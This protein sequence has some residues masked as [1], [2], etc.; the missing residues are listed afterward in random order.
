MK[1]FLMALFALLSLVAINGAL[2]TS[3]RAQDYDDDD[4][5]RRYYE[6]RYERRDD[7]SYYPRYYYRRYYGRRSS[8][9]GCQATIRAT[10]IGY[11]GGIGSRISAIRAWKREA[12]SVYNRNFSWEASKGQNITCEPYLAVIRCTAS[13]RP[14]R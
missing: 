5:R 8:G 12:Y 3:S 9:D 4:Y 1:K 6:R 2:A 13:S 10:G 7:D 14:C 11:P